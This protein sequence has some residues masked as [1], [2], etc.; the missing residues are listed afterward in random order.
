MTIAKIT[1]PDKWHPFESAS[2][3]VYT[4]G[5]THCL[6]TDVGVPDLGLE[7]HVRWS[8]RILT[9]NFDVDM[10]CGSLIWCVWRPKELTAKMCKVIAIPRRLYYDLRELVVLDVGDLFGDT[11]GTVRGHYRSKLRLKRGG[12]KEVRKVWA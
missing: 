2:F 10:V 11:P 5:K 9:R 8:K 4:V 6:R 3:I 1:Y 12:V 7:L